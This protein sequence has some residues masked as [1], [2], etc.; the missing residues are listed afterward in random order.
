MWAHAKRESVFDGTAT[1]NCVW[2]R[3]GA[4][5]CNKPLTHKSIFFFNFLLSQFSRQNSR[6]C[7]NGEKRIQFSAS[8]NITNTRPERKKY[9]QNATRKMRNSISKV[10][11]DFFKTHINCAWFRVPIF[12]SR[13][14]SNKNIIEMKSHM[15]WGGGE[16]GGVG[17]HAQEFWLTI[18]WMLGARD[19]SDDDD[20][21]N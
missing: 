13:K 7:E 19:I 5:K 10:S 21:R 16:E 11:I 6:Q 9:E 1:R 4:R 8:K 2:K 18:N 20:S 3:M 12:P 15:L 17:F 14:Y